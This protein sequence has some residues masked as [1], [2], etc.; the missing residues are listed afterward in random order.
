MRI[1]RRAAVDGIEHR[2]DAVEPIAHHQIRMRH[3]GVQHRRWIG[4]AG[5]LDDD[6]AEFYAPIVEVAEKLFQRGD[7]IAAHRAAEAAAGQQHHVAADVLDQQMIETDLAELVDQHGGVGERRV[8]QQPV[9]QRRLAGAEEAGEDAERDGFG[10]LWVS[11]CGLSSPRMRKL[12]R[13]LCA[14]AGGTLDR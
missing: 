9:E 6:A 13:K 2:D 4:E 7:E 14:S 12:G 1:E 3:D 5:R 11:A 10:A 8:L